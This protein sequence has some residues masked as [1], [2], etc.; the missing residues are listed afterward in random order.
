MLGLA[1]TGHAGV[2]AGQTA[3]RPTTLAA[4]DAY[5]SFFHRQPVV[6]QAMAEGD[7]QAVFVTDG[8]RRIRALNVAPP[9]PGQ[10]ELLEIEG[11]Y[12]DIGR[13]QPNDPRVEEHGIAR[14]SEEL[15]GK[16][17]PAT[18]ELRL[19]IADETR[20]A[21]EPEDATI[22]SIAL[23]PAGF[24]DQT[25]TVTGRFR[26]RN[27]FGDVPEAPGVSPF[28]FVLQSSNAAVWIVGKEPKG[29]D[30]ELDVMARVDTSRWLQVT[31][32]V[33]GVDELIEIEAEQIE[34]IERPSTPQPVAVTTDRRET[35]PPA[36]V[37]FS[38]PTP[39]ETDV[40]VDDLVRM[41]FS[42]DMDPESFEGHVEVEYFGAASAGSDGETPLE[43][44]VTYRRR[45]RVLNI[46]FAEPLDEYRTLEVRLTDAILAS[47]GAPLVPYTLR[48]ST[49]GS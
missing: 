7:F 8:E 22:R 1:L 33:G 2:A 10:V 13:L 42:R 43:F 5:P 25:V 3:H 31:G 37:I 11:T 34:Q 44:E 4:L 48:F 32:V 23:A 35:G 6:V 20:G 38:A 24:R 28:D 36:E 47:D 49:G 46:S 30:F 26:G 15:F 40:P 29:R 16:P 18:G 27:L 9:V 19:L 45:N 12:W 17:W 14:L 39:D 21:D 41:Q